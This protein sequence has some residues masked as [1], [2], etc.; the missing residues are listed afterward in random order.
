MTLAPLTLT[1]EA[2]HAAMAFFGNFVQ[3]GCCFFPLLPRVVLSFGA[4]AELQVSPELCKLAGAV[5]EIPFLQ[6][7]LIF[8]GALGILPTRL[9]YAWVVIHPSV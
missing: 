7:G 3:V 4:A 6:M 8:A 5:R 2:A 1:P 9:P